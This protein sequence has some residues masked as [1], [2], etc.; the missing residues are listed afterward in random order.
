MKT[1]YTKELK[2]RT[3]GA[4][5]SCFIIYFA[6]L[7]TVISYN[8]LHVNAAGLAPTV[9]DKN[10]T[11]S[12]DYAFTPQVTSKTTV[13]TFA[14]TN[15]WQHRTGANNYYIQKKDLP[16]DYKGRLGLEYHNVG[17]YQ[18]RETAL[19][20]VVTDFVAQDSAYI[21]MGDT[22]NE[23]NFWTDAAEYMTFHVELLDEATQKIINAN[24][25]FSFSD[26]D[27]GQTVGI[28]SAFSKSVASVFITDDS[29]ISATEKPNV[30]SIYYSDN[31]AVNGQTD[32]RGTITFGVKSSSSFDFA[33]ASNKTNM[34]KISVWN[35]A[36]GNYVQQLGK[37]LTYNPGSGWGID[38]SKD[39]VAPIA[40]PEPEVTG[41]NNNQ[42]QTKDNQLKSSSEKFAIDVTQTVPYAETATYFNQFKMLLN[43][44]DELV[45]DS[46]RV[47]NE[48]GKDVSGQFTCND[49]KDQIAMVAKSSELKQASFYQH[50]YD[51]EVKVHLND[52]H[53]F[54]TNLNKDSQ[55]YTVTNT[56]GTSIDGRN[57][58]EKTINTSWYS[59]AYGLQNLKIGNVPNMQ[60]QTTLNGHQISKSNKST[61]YQPITVASSPN[62]DVSW[63]LNGKLGQFKNLRNEQMENGS[64][65]L[66]TGVISQGATTLPGKS[67]ISLDSDG[68]TQVLSELESRSGNWS[69][70]ISDS[71]VNL[72]LPAKAYS[73]QYQAKLNWQLNMQ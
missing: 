48:S 44:S 27:Y 32:H 10:T 60:Y 63:Q 2:K 70:H 31:S 47:L 29:I 12:R 64:L 73:G 1:K 35:S 3:I 7:S 49:T 39:A 40:S 23:F 59:T 42:T 5:V 16:D 69:T 30:S 55:K 72:N 15:I 66:N 46:V 51:M 19:R 53:N 65:L 22:D 52:K 37:D 57:P 34:E 62:T 67:N 14:P 17:T 25:H 38:I 9:V 13:T 11:I 33:V 18:G 24:Y 68:N 61:D 36:K 41:T 45:V 54:E 43:K 8:P 71:Q 20:V 50:D 56:G 58:V 28:S 6:L 21:S 26:I 4:I